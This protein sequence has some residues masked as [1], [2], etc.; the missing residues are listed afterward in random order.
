MEKTS[1]P[2]SLWNDAFRRLVRNKAA[3]VGMIFVICVLLAAIMGPLFSV[4]SYEDAD[5]SRVSNPPFI[6]GNLEEGIQK[7]MELGG[8]SLIADDYKQVGPLYIN[9]PHWLG[10]DELGRDVLIRILYG[11]RISL[12]VG[13]LAALVSLF[14]GVI[15]GAL[16]GY[17]GGWVDAQIVRLID[18]LYSMPYM[19]FVILL[20]AI[21]GKGQDADFAFYLLFFAIGAVSWLTTARIVRGQVMSLKNSEF[22]EAARASGTGHLGIIFKHL[23]P[24]TMGP[25]VVYFSLLVPRLML[26]ESFLSF[27]GLG[28]QAPM[29][30]WGSLVADGQGVFQLYPWMVILPGLALTLTLFSLNFVG[31]GLRDALDPKLKGRQ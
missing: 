11:A 27:I 7:Y 22:V 13:F 21:A 10:T 9:Q 31:D 3:V 20:M 17:M 19:F 18:L 30:S 16:A 4:Y 6:W 15:M 5:L 24:N 25:I 1:S 12:A 2:R 28:V 29:A 8:V 23:I 14:I 26:E